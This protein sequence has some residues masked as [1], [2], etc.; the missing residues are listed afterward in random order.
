MA[1]TKWA[2]R[3]LEFT[4]CNCTYGCPCQFNGLPSHG[5]CK[6]VT[7][8]EIKTGHHG[9]TK[10]DG[11]K[12]AAIFSW[13]GPI[14]LGRGEAAVVIDKRASEAQRSALLRILTGQDTDPGATIFNVFAS[15]LEKLHPPISP[16]SSSRLTSTSVGRASKS[17]VTS[18]P[19]A[20]LF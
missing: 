18:T 11:L 8:F 12:V 2:I 9:D 13:P 10:L 20:N 6:A 16:T 1:D 17:R 7:G 14:H 3:A 19:A 4:N 15:T 5:F